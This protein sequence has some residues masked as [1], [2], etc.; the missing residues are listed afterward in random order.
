VRFF[1]RFLSLKPERI[2]ENSNGVVVLTRKSRTDS[3]D[4]SQLTYFS[5][6]TRRVLKRCQVRGRFSVL[7][8]CIDRLQL[9]ERASM[10]KRFQSMENILVIGGEDSLCY[11]VNMG[12]IFEDAPA[13]KVPSPLARMVSLLREFSR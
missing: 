4:L 12:P 13:N 2:A 9:E 1:Y 7:E 8:I 5:F 10:K 11:L 6:Q 3:K